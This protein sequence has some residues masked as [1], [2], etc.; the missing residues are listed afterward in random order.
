MNRIDDLMKEDEGGGSESKWAE[1]SYNNVAAP[2]GNESID[3]GDIAL[4][5]DLAVGAPKRKIKAT[6]RHGNIQLP[7]TPSQSPYD[8]KANAE[9]DGSCTSCS[10]SLRWY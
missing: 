4:G 5:F 8:A 10:K 9:H 1:M 2:M 3:L 6:H 7:K